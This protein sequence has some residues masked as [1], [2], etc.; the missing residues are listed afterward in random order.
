MKIMKIDEV[1]QSLEEESEDTP[2]TGA[3]QLVCRDI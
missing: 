1:R 2:V 3:S